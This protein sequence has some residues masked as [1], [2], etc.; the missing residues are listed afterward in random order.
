LPG[1]LWFP[2]NLRLLFLLYW[3]TPLIAPGTA[4]LAGAGVES[5]INETNT[6]N[7]VRV[8]WE[9]KENQTMNPFTKLTLAAA[10]LRRATTTKTVLSRFTICSTVLLL[11]ATAAAQYKAVNLV[12]DQPGLA[13]YQ[14]SNIGDAWDIAQLPNGGFA[15]A[16]A[17]TG[18]L[19]F[20]SRD[21]RTMRSPV[22]VPAAAILGSGAVGSPAGLALNPT[23]NY[24]IS[25]NGKSAPAILL[26][27]TLDGLICGWNPAVDPDNAVIVIDN[28]TESPFPA[29]YVDLSFARNRDG[30]MV[31]YVT[32]GGQTLATAN[33][34]IEIYDGNFQV[35][36]R[37]TDAFVPVAQAVYSA[38]P[39]DGKIYVTTAAFT[40]G[41]GGAVDVF[42][43]EGNFLH[44]L[45]M[46]GPGG[47]LEAPFY[48]TRAP[49]HFGFASGHLLVTNVEAGTISVFDD[50][51]TFL[52]NLQDP[53]GQD[54]VL[55]G[56]WSSVFVNGEGNPKMFYSAGC[57]FPPDSPSL[58]GYVTIAAPEDE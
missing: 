8:T 34:W 41:Q 2:R 50:D 35:L 3:M 28:S 38:R 56:L 25:K 42:D 26:I 46:N 49:K 11:A 14:D 1:I 48:V 27:A 17:W 47:T 58:F 33:N 30:N 12:A 22:R 20:Y 4:W 37:F 32:D 43:T 29:G 53:S 24:V 15:V 39:V 54:I 21:G 51:G 6:N 55:I 5:G 31:M 19:T 44:R 40:K 9:K 52:G 10:A 45:S 23:F 16:N 7:Q 57:D 36:R 18:V 13:K